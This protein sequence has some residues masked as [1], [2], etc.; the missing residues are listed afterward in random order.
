MLLDGAGVTVGAGEL[1]DDGVSAVLP[2]REPAGA[3]A[4]L[5]AAG[6]AGL[7]VE[8]EGALVEPGVGLGLR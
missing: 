6:L 4:A 2:D 5:R 1:D 7:P 3:G 8:A